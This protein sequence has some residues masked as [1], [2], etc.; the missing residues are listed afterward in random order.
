MHDVL[1]KDL[2]P[3]KISTTTINKISFINNLILCN[4]PNHKLEAFI[5]LM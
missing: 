5:H 1:I 3:N 2:T 4:I